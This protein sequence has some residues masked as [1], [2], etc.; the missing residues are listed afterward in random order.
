MPTALTLVLTAAAAMGAAAPTGSLKVTQ[1]H[2][3]P[4]C[5][6]AAPVPAGTRSWPVGDTQV[7]LTFTIRNEPRPGIANTAPGHATITF[8]P[9]PGHRY[10]VEVR[11][12]AGTF[13]RRV[14]PAGAWAPVVRDRTLD[15]VVSSTPSWAPAPCAPAS[16]QR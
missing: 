6:D 3:V 14:W 12:D 8:T 1:R 11:A 9:E 10:E 4:V 15:R 5:R 7:T 2:L 16:G 13:A